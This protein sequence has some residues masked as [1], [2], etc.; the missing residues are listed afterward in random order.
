MR[1]TTG[2]RAGHGERR[3][4]GREE[5]KSG[6]GRRVADGSPLDRRRNRR[7]DGFAAGLAR[8][9]LPDPALLVHLYAGTAYK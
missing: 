8:L 1:I 3:W 4:D 5:G 2:E 6:D 7:D 9:S